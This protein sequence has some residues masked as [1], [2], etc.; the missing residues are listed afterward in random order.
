MRNCIYRFLNKDNEIIY[1]GKAV[2]LTQRMRCHNHLPKSCYEERV[3]VEFIEFDTDD[4]MDFAERYYIAKYK[5]K[6][7]KVYINK[8]INISIHEFDNKT[9]TNEEEYLKEVRRQNILKWEQEKEAKRLQKEEVKRLKREDRKVKK[10]KQKKLNE[11]R[12]NII[13]YILKLEDRYDIKLDINIDDYD[14]N[15][16]NFRDFYDYIDNKK[17]DLVN[18]INY[19]NYYTRNV[20][21]ISTGEMF[22]NLI[23]YK[24]KLGLRNSIED[25]RK[26][27]DDKEKILLGNYH[28]DYYGIFTRP[29]YL[30]RF[31]KLDISIQ[32]SILKKIEQ[33]KRGI[34]CITDGIVYSN[35][36]EASYR[37]NIPY[38][39]IIKC[40]NHKANYVRTFNNKPLVWKWY[41][42]Y[43][44]MTQE[45]I[46]AYMDKAYEVYFKRNKGKIA[47]TNFKSKS[48]DKE[49]S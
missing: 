23:E 47:K 34:I 48:L 21:C 10:E 18:K 13:S 38:C 5:P 8:I 42:E 35:K 20:M 32:E 40:C 26:A 1:I 43:L 45:E 28:P 46:N 12:I 4:E 11:I 14:I 37:T 22:D 25:L 7:N 17:N 49:V 24:E 30:D 41:D 36:Y 3:T 29:I 16:E 31:E 33:D 6:Y 15:T 2:N 27:A 44:N 39:D 19:A 9:W